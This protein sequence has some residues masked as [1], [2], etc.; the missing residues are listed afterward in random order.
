MSEP[1]T[2]T[3]QWTAVVRAA[4]FRCQCEGACGRTHPTSRCPAEHDKQPAKHRAPVRLTVAPADPA[5]DPLTA[6]R[7]PVTG[8]RAWCGPCHDNARRTARKASLAEL[9]PDA[10][11]FDV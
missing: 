9:A 3:A 1:I 4:G 5:T 11:L 8:L 6:A 2:M 7:T 10:G